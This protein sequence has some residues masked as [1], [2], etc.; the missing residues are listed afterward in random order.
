M[1]EQEGAG[2]R[3]TVLGLNPGTGSCGWCLLDASSQEILGMG[4][5]VFQAPLNPKSKVSLARERR[6]HYYARVNRRRT[7]RR[8]KHVL[9]VLEEEG[10]VPEGSDP[11]WL[12]SRK[13]ELPIPRLRAEALDR[14]LSP[15]ELAQLLYYYAA[16]RGYATGDDGSDPDGKRILTA[17]ADNAAEFAEG[18]WRTVGQMLASR[19][20]MRNRAG[21]YRNA[22]SR[23]M[24]E[25]EVEEVLNAQAALG[26][27][28][29][30]DLRAR[31]AEAFSFAPS[32]AKR[33]AQ[34]Y[35]RVG[36][37]VYFPDEKRAARADLSH[38]MLVALERL[39]HLRIEFD[40][41]RSKGLPAYLI[42]SCMAR[43]FSPE[44]EAVVTYASIRRDLASRIPGNWS[45]KAVPADGERR[46]VADP[47]AW[48]ALRSGLPRNLADRLLADL[49]LADDVCE[50]LTYSSSEEVLADRLADRAAD[51]SDS[52]IDALLALP[53]RSRAFQGYGSRS[54][55]A[56]GILLEALRD[57]DV[58][59]LRDAEEDTG[60]LALRLRSR[61]PERSSRLPAYS[62]Y[63]PSCTNP[64]VLRAASRMRKVV[65]AVSARWGVPNEIRIEL[66]RDLKRS[67]RERDAIARSNRE[68]EKGNE[69]ARAAAAEAMGV[70]PDDVPAAV[71]RKVRLWREQGE[72]DLFT[73]ESIDF[74]RMCRGRGY[75]QECHI[76]PYSRTGDDGMRNR[77][78][79]L[80]KSVQ[81]KG[82][83]SP[84]E[85][86]GGEGS[87]RWDAFTDRVR[88]ASGLP[89]AKRARLLE[90]DLAGKQDAL[91]QRNLNDTRYMSV[92][93][94]D[95]LAD[96]LLFPEEGPARRVQAVSGSATALLR[97]VWGLSTPAALDDDGAA[98]SSRRCRSASDA[99]VIAACSAATLVKCARYSE[100]RLFLPPE[101]RELELDGTQPWQGFADQVRVARAFVIPTLMVDRG[102]T[103]EALEQ[104]A[105]GVRRIDSETGFAEL[106]GMNRL[107]GNYQLMADGSARMVS[108]MAF[109]RL[110]LDPVAPP[111]G[112]RKAQGRYYAEPVYFNDIPHL[113][114]PGRRP[115]HPAKGTA[116]PLWPE[117]PEEALRD[118][119]LVLH[120]GQLI[121]VN[122][123]VARYKG[124]MI[125]TNQ[126]SVESALSGEEVKGFPTI[127]S[128]SAADELELVDEDAIGEV[129]NR[130]RAEGARIA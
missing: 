67:K 5:H 60:L 35:A 28:F 24:I 119:P 113:S 27:P 22:V 95:F 32:T 104:T 11:S 46:A 17:I 126:W 92:A 109:L 38:E 62:S 15:R 48:K 84:R 29:S 13:G 105:R 37:C 39:K 36:A 87:P 45:F 2:G 31:Y 110:W 49:D 7:K 23:Q 25:Q 51:L 30:P 3:Y 108:K 83:R 88:A 123:L 64:V 34:V 16:H 12:Q 85:W 14:R 26:S 75:A 4:V 91:L 50:A 89:A 61:G 120:A 10:L 9:A 53:F 63:D 93:F 107:A 106:S 52:D 65:N 70:A 128:L 102:S 72:I 41:G 81:D 57:P 74:G 130:L 33:D 127:A 99:A 54:R 69:S 77:I 98:G 6:A 40:D 18:P 76:L 111:R 73:G 58:P 68:R 116:R 55:K 121:S 97:R 78:L 90:A 82:A 79:A 1:G 114:D 118:R 80:A 59:T 101:E 71:L 112:K 96:C 43:I 125:S 19:D 117:I 66:G 47:K 44:P 56:V 103:G 124:F 42:D 94:R 20:R 115:R 100:Q 122:G 21:D 129:W 86:L 8:L